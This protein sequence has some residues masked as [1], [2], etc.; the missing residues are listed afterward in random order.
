M[1]LYVLRHG[2]AED[3]SPSGEDSDRRLTEEGRVKLQRVLERAR[4][5]GARPELTLTSP[6]ARARRTAE[7][8][9]QALGCDS[10]PTLS[11]NLFPYSNLLDTWEEIRGLRELDSLML[12][13]HNP[14]LS[15]LVSAVTGAAGGGVAMKKAALAR[16]E[17]DPTAAA[18]RGR[19][20][21]LLTPKTAG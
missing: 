11:S 13:G 18:P 8:T 10:E 16:L 21:W 12:V 15:E 19:L 14:H 1:T 4:E 20:E 2:I 6:Y 9:T 5:A 3:V 7:L 17:V